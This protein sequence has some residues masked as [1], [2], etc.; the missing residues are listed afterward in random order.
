MKRQ[1]KSPKHSGDA[2][3]TPPN[4]HRT[5]R[6]LGRRLS[7][8]SDTTY[9][10]VESEALPNPGQ[11]GRSGA[12]QTFRSPSATRE[13]MAAAEYQE[14]PFQG[15]LKCTTI[16]NEIT[17]NVV[18]KLPRVSGC[19][20]LPINTVALGIPSDGKTSTSRATVHGARSQPKTLS[21]TKEAEPKGGKWTPEEDE[22]VR[23]MRE[24]GHSWDEIHGAL[25]H[26]TKATIQV[27][28]STKLKN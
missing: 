7:P 13:S 15:F 5:W 20:S 9:L 6:R 21:T 1:K 3:L 25:P 10:S 4:K 19:V 26:R 22:T 23:S 24:N 18:F 8:T 14:W 11:D 17:Y 27:R 2:A 28:Y 16:G 12:S